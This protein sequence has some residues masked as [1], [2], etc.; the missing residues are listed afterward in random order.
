VSLDGKQH[1]RVIGGTFFQFEQKAFSTFLR[2]LDTCIKEVIKST[3]YEEHNF[4]NYF[5]N[6]IMDIRDPWFIYHLKNELKLL[7]KERRNL[8]LVAQTRLLLS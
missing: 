7:F 2:P 4:F 6:S 8:H 5:F 1:N 3:W